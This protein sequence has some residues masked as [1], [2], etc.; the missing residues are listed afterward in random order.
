MG[1]TEITEGAVTQV[2]Q[3][4]GFSWKPVETQ[5]FSLNSPYSPSSNQSIIHIIPYLSYLAKRRVFMVALPG[6]VSTCSFSLCFFQPSWDNQ[7]DLAEAL[8][9]AACSV[10][11]CGMTCH[12]PLI[13]RT[14]L[15]VF[16]NHFST[17]GIWQSRTCFRKKSLCLG[18]VCFAKV[19][20]LARTH[21]NSW[22]WI[23]NPFSYEIT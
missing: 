12:A 6:P 16:F 22:V 2:P 5:G 8:H 10:N 15:S 7:V 19:V 4:P 9:I 3:S 11:L 20:P 18:E 14:Y 21:R 23:C 1:V 13:I 17:T